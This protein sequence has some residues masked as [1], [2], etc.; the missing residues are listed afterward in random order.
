MKSFFD[1]FYVN[2]RN[3]CKSPI[4]EIYFNVYDQ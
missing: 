4:R 3:F 2:I 1:G